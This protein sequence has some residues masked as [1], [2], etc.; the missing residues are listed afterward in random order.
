M[1]DAVALRQGRQREV[2]PSVATETGSNDAEQR[3][4]L[5]H[6]QQRPAGLALVWS[7]AMEPSFEIRV[8]RGIVLRRA[9]NRLREEAILTSLLEGVK[10]RRVDG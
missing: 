10:C 8:L 2:L 1:Q 9:L 7:R 5:S 6:W 4:V 3:L